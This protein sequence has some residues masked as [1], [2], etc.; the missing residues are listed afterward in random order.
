MQVTKRT[1]RGRIGGPSK[2]LQKK[3]P[4][5]LKSFGRPRNRA[6]GPSRRRE[7]SS[8]LGLPLVRPPLG[9]EDDLGHPFRR[10][11]MG[12]MADAFERC[13]PRVGNVAR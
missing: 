1:L 12:R 7:A 6:A 8:P 4:K 9:L 2:E 10:D 11:M 13:E 5:T 3:T